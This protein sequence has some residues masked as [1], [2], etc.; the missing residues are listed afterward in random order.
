MELWKIVSR[1][2]VFLLYT[3][4]FLQIKFLLG[5]SSYKHILYFGSS[6]SYFPAS[7]ESNI[8]QSFYD[9]ETDLFKD[10]NLHFKC[11]FM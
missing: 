3:A 1:S 6:P 5:Q 7:F 8:F 11:V 10:F 9:G 4:D 2:S